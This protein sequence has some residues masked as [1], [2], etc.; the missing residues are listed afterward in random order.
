MGRQK[1]N[2]ISSGE[3]LFLQTFKSLLQHFLCLRPEISV[4][5]IFFSYFEHQEVLGSLLAGSG[6][7]GSGPERDFLP[8]QLQHEKI[9]LNWTDRCLYS[10]MNVNIFNS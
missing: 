6:T 4:I 7:L 2:Y 1:Q 8:S 10:L 3:M 9:P 5:Q